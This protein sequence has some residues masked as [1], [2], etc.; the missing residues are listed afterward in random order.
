M[1]G[2]DQELEA[3]LRPLSNMNPTPRQISQWKDAVRST[4]KQRFTFFSIAPVYQLTVAVIFGIA[5]G[6]SFVS[7]HSPV[8]TS[9][10]G[11]P[12][13]CKCPV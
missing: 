1:S 4:K 11:S 13:V 3:L 7:F 10:C 9:I 8:Q 2:K 6:S 12:K 5:I